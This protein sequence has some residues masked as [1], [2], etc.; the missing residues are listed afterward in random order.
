MAK[1]LLQEPEY[2]ITKQ[3]HTTECRWQKFLHYLVPVI[4][5]VLHYKLPVLLTLMSIL[6]V[7]FIFKVSFF[8]F[9]A[10]KLEKWVNFS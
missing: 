9:V 8:I 4:K 7:L 2:W 6:S 10:G 5:D 3:G 1:A